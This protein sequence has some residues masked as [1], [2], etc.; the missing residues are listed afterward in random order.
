[1]EPGIYSM[2]AAEYHSS[3]GVSKSMLDR[4][5]PTPLHFHSIKETTDPMEFGQCVHSLLLDREESYYVYPG[6]YESDGIIKKW[7]NNANVCRT[8]VSEHSDKPILTRDEAVMVHAMADSIHSHPFAGPALR[9]ARVEQSM[10]AIEPETEQLVRCRVDAIPVLG[11]ISGMK[12]LLD[13]KTVV[14]ADERSFN[15][16]LFKRRLHVQGAAYIKIANLLGLDVDSFIFIV[17]EKSPP[18]AV[19]IYD[20]SP[21]DIRQGNR[22]YMRD[23]RTYKQ[24]IATGNWPGYQTTP[25][26]TCL[27]DYAFD[28]MGD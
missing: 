24:C 25:R 17:V 8:W 7:N 13:V 18:Y 22:E 16:V 2:S 1:M 28:I 10:F 4:L 20:L 15:K 26:M 3:P 14:A 9:G 19:A 21:D 27:P 12:P 5:H 23:L 11:R 6:M